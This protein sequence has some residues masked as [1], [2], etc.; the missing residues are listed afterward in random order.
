M[1]RLLALILALM[2]VF[3]LAACGGEDA[4]KKVEDKNTDNNNV[5]DKADPTEAP[6]PMATIGDVTLQFDSAVMYKPYDNETNKPNLL[7]YYTFTN[8][9][10][11]EVFP[12]SKIYMKATQDNSNISAISYLKDA[13][14][15]EMNLFY[16]AVQPGETVRLVE[17][18]QADIEGGEVTVEFIDLYNQ[19]EETLVVKTTPSSLELIKES[20]AI[21]EET[22]E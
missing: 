1:K 4:D 20:L 6:K 10:D 7:V 13:I 12:S 3:S 8:N 11:T 19:I 16:K 17:A 5:A 22:T 2:M 18:F 9:S 14:P 15:P 21:D